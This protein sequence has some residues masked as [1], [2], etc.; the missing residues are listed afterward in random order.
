VV[1]AALR[2][3]RGEALVLRLDAFDSDRVFAEA[4]VDAPHERLAT[5]RL[6]GMVASR[7]VLVLDGIDAMQRQD[8]PRPGEITDCMFRQL[9]LA[10]CR[11]ALPTARIVVTSRLGPPS[12]LPERSLSL[13]PLPPAP[14]A[15]ASPLPRAGRSSAACWSSPPSAAGQS[16]CEPCGG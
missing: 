16:T 1:E 7:R 15:D 10:A 6:L 9:L 12:A 8:G 2:P 13:L 4:G 14:P 5:R 11:G 3:G